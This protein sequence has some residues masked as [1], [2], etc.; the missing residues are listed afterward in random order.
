MRISRN[1]AMDDSLSNNNPHR[2][3]NLLTGEWILVSPH[4]AKRPWQGK[5]E[6]IIPQDQPEHD[7]NCYL[8]PGNKRKNGQNN[9]E[10]KHT[11]TFDNDF[12]ALL[13]KANSQKNIDNMD[14]LFITQDVFGTARVICF[15]PKHN[16]SMAQM[17]LDSIKEVIITWGKEVDALAK[18]YKWVQVFENKGDIMGCSSPHPHGQIWASKHLPN[19]ACKEC[20]QQEEFFNKNNANL[21]LTYAKSEIK[22]K[23]RVIIT[24][25]HWVVVIPFWAMWPFETLLLPKNRVIN[26]LNDLTEDEQISLAKILKQLLSAYDNLFNVSF[27]FSMGWHGS[28]FDTNENPNSHANSWQCHAHFYPPLLRSATN[29]KFMVGYEM[30]AEPQRDITPE[31]AAIQLREAVFGN[32]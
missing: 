12:P 13:D 1:K 10:Y 32:N 23:V 20:K 6:P 4:R 31:Q 30:L 19:E 15:S 29:K 18:K 26:H 24:D 27:P 5:A 9:P 17:D 7:P 8:C 3:F 11:Y 22:K 28:P 16:I 14:N 25:E 21:L 2:R